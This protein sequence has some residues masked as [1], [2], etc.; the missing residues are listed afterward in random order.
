MPRRWLFA[1]RPRAQAAT[2]TASP[3]AAQ[4]WVQRLR[5]PPPTPRPIGYVTRHGIKANNFVTSLGNT[6]PMPLS[7][8]LHICVTIYLDRSDNSLHRPCNAIDIVPLI[9]YT[10]H[11][12]EMMEEQEWDENQLATWRCHRRNGCGCFGPSTPR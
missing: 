2:A 3:R 8:M 12:T 1:A 7:I 4:A 6:I 5:Q 9:R 10:C 11:V